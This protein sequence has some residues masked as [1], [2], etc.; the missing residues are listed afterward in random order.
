MDVFQQQVQIESQ[1]LGQTVGGTHS[2]D[3]NVIRAGNGLHRLIEAAAVAGPQG[4]VQLVRVHHQHGFQH[5]VLVDHL[6]GHFDAL[7]AGE[8][9]ADHLLNRLSHLGIPLVSQIAGET[10]H[11]GLADAH[12]LPQLSRRHKRGLVIVLAD[13]LRDAALPLGE[14][15]AVFLQPCQ[16]IFFHS[17]TSSPSF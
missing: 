1:K 2:H 12:R 15:L 5:I 4:G 3:V 7:Q 9:G 11:G 8:A 16:D 6:P 10:D 17:L 13:K 14:S